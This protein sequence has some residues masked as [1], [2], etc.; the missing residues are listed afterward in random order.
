M[1]R[2][3]HWD[4]W[5]RLHNVFETKRRILQI[6]KEKQGSNEYTFPRSNYSHTHEG[7][8]FL[9]LPKTFEDDADSDSNER[10]DDGSDEGGGEGSDEDSDEG[11]NEGSERGK[12]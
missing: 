5:T 3:D 7:A 9:P 4:A 12:K 6:V 1:Q 2:W 8:S 11:G 10:S